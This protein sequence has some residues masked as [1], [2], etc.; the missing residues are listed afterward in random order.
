M[1]PGY[2]QICSLFLIPHT[3]LTDYSPWLCSGFRLFPGE[4]G[5]HSSEG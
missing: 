5:N 1:G 3:L 2:N 4:L